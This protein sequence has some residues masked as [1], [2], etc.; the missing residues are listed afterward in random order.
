M[1]YFEK[2]NNNVESVFLFD[3][4]KLY[5]EKKTFT[6]T[7]QSPRKFC[8]FEGFKSILSDIIIYD[9]QLLFHIFKVTYLKIIY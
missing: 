3:K 6:I 5:L 8:Y 7:P 4:N 2:R 1:C 9:P